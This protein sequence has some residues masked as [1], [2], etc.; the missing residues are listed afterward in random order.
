MRL[1]SDVLDNWL[2]A[3]RFQIKEDDVRK[4]FGKNGNITDIKLVHKNGEFR[5]YG[6]IG[7]E[8]EDEASEACKYF[9]N[10]FIKQSRITVELC[11]DMGKFG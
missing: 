10:T 4:L 11:H 5:R 1:V 2:D 3:L 6:F 7:Y 9:N 8:K